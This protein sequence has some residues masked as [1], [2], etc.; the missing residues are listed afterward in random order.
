MINLIDAHIHL[1]NPKQV[2]YFWLSPELERLNRA[3]MPIDL[4]PELS[5]NQ[6][7]KAVFIQASH[8]SKENAF[9]LELARGNPFIAGVVGWLDLESPSLEAL[10]LELQLNPVFKGLRHLVHTEPDPN[11]LLRPTVQIGLKLLEQHGS[12]FDLVLR[13]DQWQAA[14]V[15][16]RR[17][18]NLTLIVDHLGNPPQDES[19]FLLWRKWL[20]QMA[21]CPNVYAKCSGV[22][23]HPLFNQLASAALELIGENRL[24]FGSDSPIATGLGD[25]RQNLLALQALFTPEQ[26]GFWA[27][28]AKRAYRLTTGES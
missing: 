13:P 17:Y 20:S 7:C 2:D 4:E 24:M 23:T 12:S 28:N 5:A 14:L 21:Q 19:G 27:D 16:A 22:T 3:I 9:A 11:W 6:V 10:L 8:D 15:V 1:W 18:P 25:Y 26:T